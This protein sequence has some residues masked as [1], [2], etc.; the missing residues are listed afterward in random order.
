V[1]CIRLWG[2]K[3]V[4][5][6]I[7]WSTILIGLGELAIAIGLAPTLVSEPQVHGLAVLAA[8]GVAFTITLFARATQEKEQ[9]ESG[10]RQSEQRFKALVQHASDIILV[11]DSDGRLQY[12]SPA[13]AL[14]LGHPVESTLGR[15]GLD[16]AEPG[17]VAGLRAALR[18][19]GTRVH[20]AEV[21]MRHRDGRWFWFE[22]TVTSLFD[23]PSVNGWVANLRDVTERKESEAALQEAQAAFRHAFDDAPIGM[24][25]VDLQGRILRANRA[26][27]QL[28]ERT[29]HELVG[30]AVRDI[31]HPDDR[32]STGEELRRLLA[33]KRDQYRLEKRYVRPGGE[34]VW[35]S[36]SVSLVRDADQQPLYC[37]GQ[38]EDITERK[39]LA[40]RLAHEAAHD[41]MTG[42]PNRVRFMDRLILALQADAHRDSRVAVLFVDLD[43]FKVINDGLGHAAGDQVLATISDRLRRVLRPG[44]VVAR[45]GG[46]EFTVLCDDVSGEEAVLELATRLSTAIAEPIPLGSG[47]VF[48]TASVGI[49]LSGGDD[50]TPEALL[51]DADTAMY[52]AKA[53]GRA[54]TF[55]FREDNRELAVTQLRTANELHRALE[56]D[57]F[58]V[59]YQPIMR[60]DDRGL[61]GFEALLRWQHPERGLLTP[62]DF[63]G[64]A[65]DTGLI[66]SIGDWVLETACEQAAKW[67]SLGRCDR[68]RS[69]TINVNLSPRQLAEPSLASRAAEIL[70]RSRLPGSA[71][72]LE[73]TENTLMHNTDSVIGAMHALREQ[74]I[75]LS[76]DD[77]GTGYSS[78]AYLQRFPVESL[79]IDRRFVDG[80]GQDSGASSIVQAVVNLAHALGLVAVA[81]GLE[82]RAQLRA[83]RAIGC[84]L[85]QGYLLGHP[86]APDQIEFPGIVSA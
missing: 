73:L 5:P 28:F 57:E 62:G 52:R 72:C 24:A 68:S 41:S 42:L 56:R 51:R 59:Y 64:L 35:A 54:Q 10:L 23:D 20:R 4:V 71:L 33:G 58:R 78:L 8:L 40:D 43:Q 61:V 7:V 65:E 77:F 84:D 74:G 48:V 15:Q 32:E 31:T 81:E 30:V 6:A 55:V 26:I 38:L 3:G 44:D 46:D 80:L 75:H 86:A 83:L 22:V 69:L 53:E 19:D 9:A 39:E 21:R 76:I 27:G 1:D 13:F 18:D 16:F 37:I 17:D 85:A 63:I 47:E 45:F 36:L 79:K 34:V 50:D 25:L 70:A 49:A 66:V 2:R 11:M 12:V 14:V 60:L 82:T 29:Q 67:R